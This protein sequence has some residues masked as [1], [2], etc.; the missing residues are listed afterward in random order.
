[1]GSHHS[2]AGWVTARWNRASTMEV[3]AQLDSETGAVVL[4]A[5]GSREAISVVH[6]L[7]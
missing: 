7:P 3:H 2:D 1:M 4:A 6:V 5:P